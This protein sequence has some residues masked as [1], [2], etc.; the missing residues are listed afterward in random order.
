MGAWVCDHVGVSLLQV[1]FEKQVS[2]KGV[3]P[4]THLGRS[5]KPCSAGD[6][7]HPA[8]GLHQQGQQGLRDAHPG[9]EVHVHDALRLHEPQVD[10]AGH[11]GQAQ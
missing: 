10:R 7:H 4:C 2:K 11:P 9:K 5:S 3:Q 6:V 8:L 1:F